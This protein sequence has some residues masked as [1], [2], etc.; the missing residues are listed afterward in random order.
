M[1]QKFEVITDHGALLPHYCHPKLSTSSLMGLPLKLQD[2]CNIHIRK[3]KQKSNTG[4][5]TGQADTN[6]SSMLY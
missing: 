2:S 6:R 4:D 1:W 5:L 3:G